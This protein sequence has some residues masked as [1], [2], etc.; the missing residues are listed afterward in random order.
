MYFVELCKCRCWTSSMPE[1]RP[2]TRA[3]QS[4]YYS[5]TTDFT[6]TLW[7]TDQRVWVFP[8]LF[9]CTSLVPHPARPRSPA[10]QSG[11]DV[12][13]SNICFSF[14]VAYAGTRNKLL[15]SNCAHTSLPAKW[16]IPILAAYALPICKRMRWSNSWAMNKKFYAIA[17]TVSGVKLRYTWLA[18]PLHARFAPTTYLC[19][20]DSVLT[21]LSI[22][23]RIAANAGSVNAL[24]MDA[25]TALERQGL[26]V[27]ASSGV[28]D[29]TGKHKS[30]VCNSQQFNVGLPCLLQSAC[31]C[32]A[33][34]VWDWGC[35]EHS[36]SKFLCRAFSVEQ[37]VETAT[38]F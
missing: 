10:Q 16:Q 20:L 8:P 14:R 29:S 31:S 38:L 12:W 19:H 9:A 6:H 15:N 23:C 36:S 13:A 18:P 21:D 1:N 37:R 11:A 17:T 2:C 34:H 30:G 33:H 4:D 24:W 26:S 25:N 32:I 5:G 7:H 28:K 35:C 22:S 27:A 3:E